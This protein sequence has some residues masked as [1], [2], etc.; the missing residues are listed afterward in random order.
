M[1]RAWSCDPFWHKV[2]LQGCKLGTSAMYKLFCC[3]LKVL[4][5]WLQHRISSDKIISIL[6]AQWLYRETQLPL[7]CKADPVLKCSNSATVLDLAGVQSQA[8]KLPLSLRHIFQQKRVNRKRLKQLNKH[9]PEKVEQMVNAY[10]ESCT[11]ECCEVCK[12]GREIREVPGNL[13]NVLVAWVLR[14]T[15][16]E[17]SGDTVERQMDKIL[18]SKSCDFDHKQLCIFW[19]FSHEVIKNGLLVYGME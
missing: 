3:V 16:K 15:K 11:Q 17:Q 10:F 5:K 12:L 19:D 9:S 8:L 18:G 2:V 13:N 7:N 1:E 4:G 6:L 14:Q